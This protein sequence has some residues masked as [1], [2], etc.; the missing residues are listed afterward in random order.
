ML[1]LVPSV[2]GSI[3]LKFIVYAFGKKTST[4]LMYVSIVV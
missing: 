1:H 2:Y 4:D 3:I